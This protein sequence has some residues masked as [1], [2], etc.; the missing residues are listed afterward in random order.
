MPGD[1]AVR[2]GPYLLDARI[3]V[4]G[5]AEVYLAHPVDPRDAG[6][7]RLVVKRLLP[8]YLADEEGRTMFEREAALHAAVRHEN[9][10][11]VFGS[12]VTESGEP[13][14]AM[15]YV[16]GTDGYRL[17]RRLKA[18]RRSLSAAVAVHVMRGVLRALACAH[19]ATD[20]HGR[21]LKIVHRD[22]TPSNVYLSSTGEV[23][24]GDFGIARSALRANRSQTSAVL[25]GKFAYLA[26]EQVASEPF[27]LRADLFSAGTVLV[28]LLLGEPL[29]A[30]A[31][32][33][34]V[35]LAIRD[36]RLDGLHAAK[37]LLPDGLYE[38][39]LTALARHP[40]QRFADA[41]AF[42]AALAPFDP[43][44]AET[45][46]ELARLVTHVMRSESTDRMIAVRD[47][48][49]RVMA[50]RPHEPEE[51]RPSERPTGEYTTQPSFVRTRDGRALGPWTFAQ[52]VEAI[53]TGA[54]GRADLVDYMGT[55]LR[56]LDAIA[57]LARF[58]PPDS[59]ATTDVF[60]PRAEYSID[61]AQESIL[62][63]L[64]R[65]LENESTGALFV[66]DSPTA[67][68]VATGARKELY[69]VRGRL[70]HVASSNAS[71]LL[72]EYLVR[73]GT[74]AREE[75]DMALAVL[76]RNQG[77][78][79][80]TL[81]ALGLVEPVTLFKAIREQGR[82]RVVDL[83]HWRLGRA[84][85]Y[86]N[87]TARHVEFPLDL[88]LTQILM[89]GLEAALPGEEPFERY[90]GKLGAALVVGPRDRVGLTHVR[91]PELAAAVLA[92]AKRG[93]RLSDAVTEL[94]RAY[95]ATASEVLRALELVRAARLVALA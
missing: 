21:P 1:A 36:C 77:R 90:R 13:Y 66:N 9:V 83:F 75:P 88:D 78:M 30:G 25:K 81:I 39:L 84:S 48:E 35:L 76:P 71:E 8:D 45:R 38:V 20:D 14:L 62:E 27:D 34:A 51:A 59:S 58:L 5:T 33:L 55:G 63:P 53:A 61:L 32:Q 10:V 64:L 52:L 4:G 67:V 95:N 94:T 18:E 50:V 41:D 3:A 73:R 79:G 40:E 69:F 22:V 60:G 24:L 12:G 47:S 23:K 70:H 17:L 6:P 31:G 89:A 49:R 2:F 37:H 85:F 93:G 68:P 54:I 80:D 74:I 28:E 16:E 56:A 87:E 7:R 91:W 86:R 26:P 57:D 11:E 44:P 19:A 42:Y 15:E 82:D 43:T 46:A 72:G 92:T 65:V 29:F